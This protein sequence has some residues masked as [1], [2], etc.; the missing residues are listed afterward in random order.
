MTKNIVI[1][2]ILTVL[3]TQT[4]CW[5]ASISDTSGTLLHDNAVTI[6][7]NGF[8]SKTT[9]EPLHFETFEDNDSDDITTI[10]ED[11]SKDIGYWSDR[12]SGFENPKIS[13]S[14]TRGHYSNRCASSYLETKDN[15]ATS[16]EMMWRNEVGFT[17]D[18]M[19]IN[20]WIYHQWVLPPFVLRD[21]VNSYQIKTVYTAP[22][23]NDNGS[24]GETTEGGGISTF[25]LR[26]FYSLGSDEVYGT[27]D[28]YTWSYFGV[29]GGSSV[30]LTRPTFPADESG[31]WYNIIME[32]E[33]G[34]KGVA[35]GSYNISVSNPKDGAEYKTVSATDYLIRG[36]DV[37]DAIELG[38]FL[39]ESM[40]GTGSTTIYYD[41]IYL[42]NSFAH[43]EIGDNVTYDLCTH[44]E[45]QPPTAWSDTGID[46]TL[47]QGAFAPGDTVYIFVTDENGIVSDQDTSTAGAQGFAI[48][49]ETPS[50]VNLV[51]SQTSQTVSNA[52]TQFTVTGTT[53]NATSVICNPVKSNTGT[54]EAFIFADIPL[55][56]GAN[57]I[58]VTASDGVDAVP[59]SITITREPASYPETS[60]KGSALKGVTI[61]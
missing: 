48:V 35:N 40:M 45:I 8:G 51:I 43:V 23:F 52:T 19:Y 36:G 25:S 46:L 6:T 39:A 27:V 16:A 32:I 9:A 13:N 5:A 15:V 11:V 55:S 14:V 10:G 42:D 29:Y 41:D 38:W 17:K 58:T 56:V 53:T 54:V 3:M 24:Y 22:M 2:T 59:K 4:C 44:M 20:L 21:G 37:I 28:D 31:R 12:G 34:D 26:S 1:I 7:G 30:N 60:F 18:R 57:V 33:Q 50:D 61:P 47:N 49:L